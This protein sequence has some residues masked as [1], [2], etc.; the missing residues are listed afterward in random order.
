MAE[1]LTKK[2]S[3]P[4]PFPYYFWTAMG[5]CLVGLAAA[6]HLS[7]S[8]YRLH[9]DVSYSSFCAISKSINCDTVSQS[10][11]AIL[12]GLPIAV[13]GIFGYLFLVCLLTASR[14]RSARGRRVWT[15]IFCVAAGF[16]AYSIALAAVSTFLIGSYCLLCVT[17]YA[18]NLL[19]LFFSWIIRR[20]FDSGPFLHALGD[21]LRHLSLKRPLNALAL[22]GLLAAL[23]GAKAFYPAYWVFTPAPL[24]A[25]VATGVTPEGHPWIGAEQPGIG[26]H[27]VCGLSML[28]VQKNVFPPQG[29]DCEIP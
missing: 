17:L 16:S 10:P 3:S 5:L 22:V 2:T 6:A 21:D 8:H 11:Y 28:S 1:S 13:W 14:S 29:S 9:T 7:L 12:W 19:L 18:V 27:R 20:R 4:L 26:N 15:L 25:R 24:S 23:A